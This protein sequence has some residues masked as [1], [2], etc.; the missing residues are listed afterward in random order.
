M[1]LP[2]GTNFVCG[3]QFAACNLGF[4]LSEVGIFF[5]RKLDRRLID[6][7]ELQQDARELVL[8]RVREGRYFAKGLF[9][10]TCHVSQLTT[11]KAPAKPGPL[12]VAIGKTDQRE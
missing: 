12:N 11:K 6:A 8:L 9:E 2:H 4:G 5:R 1:L 10:Q 7:R 3:S